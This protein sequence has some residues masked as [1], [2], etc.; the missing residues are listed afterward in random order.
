MAKKPKQVEY[1]DPE[2]QVQTGWYADG[3][4]YTD[5]AATQPIPEGSTF[6]TGSGWSG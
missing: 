5:E 3:H 6:R 1:T 4:V 2:G